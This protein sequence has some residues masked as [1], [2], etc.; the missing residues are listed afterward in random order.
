MEGIVVVQLPKFVKTRRSVGLPD[1][2]FIV[3]VLT[4]SKT[5]DFP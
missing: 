5:R 1:A 4:T 3:A 2:P